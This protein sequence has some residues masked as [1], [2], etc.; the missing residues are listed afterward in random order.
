MRRD[1]A[2]PLLSSFL[3][4][5]GL[6]ELLRVS[7]EGEVFDYLY[8]YLI[9]DTLGAMYNYPHGRPDTRDDEKP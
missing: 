7:E 8:S 1:S 2:K 3:A 4:S 5:Q 9:G 6:P